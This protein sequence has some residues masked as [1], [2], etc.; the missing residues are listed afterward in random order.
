LRSIRRR[1]FVAPTRFAAGTPYKIHEAASFGLPVVATGIL[2]QQLGWGDGQDLLAADANP[3]RFAELVVKLYRD[4]ALWQR[5]RDAALQRIR[6]ETNPADYAEAVRRIMEPAPPA[7]AL[8]G[9]GE[10][11]G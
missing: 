1:I 9:T 5:L 8:V 7:L 6:T 3:A 4:P 11:T 2:R 10:P